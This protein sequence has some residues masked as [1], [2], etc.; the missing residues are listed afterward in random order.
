MGID[1]LRKNFIEVYEFD[2]ISL[3][4]LHLREELLKYELVLTSLGEGQAQVV[5]LLDDVVD[6][7]V[8]EGR[9]RRHTINYIRYNA[10]FLLI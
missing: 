8:A 7:Q 3:V 9:V 5:V 10:C 1:S 4:V 2:L 6:A